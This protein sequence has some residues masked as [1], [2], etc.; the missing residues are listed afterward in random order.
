[1]II[2]VPK[3]SFP[4]ENRVALIPAH[5]SGIINTGLSVLIERGAG[6]NA[7]FPDDLYKEK[8][9]VIVETREELFSRADVLL[10]VRAGGANPTEG[11]KDLKLMKEESEVRLFDKI[12]ELHQIANETKV[13][14]AKLP[15][16]VHKEKFN[17]INSKIKR[18]WGVVL[19]I[20]SGIIGLGWTA[21]KG[22]Q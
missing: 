17:G 3:E 20:L 5:I 1:M 8:G 9:A 4:G 6:I 22:G 10:M 2:G 19:L 13:S 14:M 21:L 18:L 15:C 7:G 12:D 11:K 16:G